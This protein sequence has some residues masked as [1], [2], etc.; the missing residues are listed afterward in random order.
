VNLRPVGTSPDNFVQLR[1]L[2]TSLGTSQTTW[3]I[4]TGLGTSQTTCDITW[5]NQLKHHFVHLRPI[6]TSPA[7]LFVAAH[8]TWYITWYISVHL[9]HLQ[10]TWYISDHLGHLR[11]LGTSPHHLVHLRPLGTA[12]GTTSWYITSFVSG[13][14]VSPGHIVQLRAF[15]TSL[16]VAQTSADNL[17]PQTT[18]Y[19]T[20]D[21][22]DHLVRLHTT[23]YIAD[24]LVHQW[25]RPVGT[26]LNSSQSTW[27]FT[28]P[29]VTAQTTWF[30][31]SQCTWCISRQLGSS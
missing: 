3:Y 27:Y 10:A 16:G 13:Y 11:P 2:G 30:G 22:S 29:R 28:K 19:I 12:L 23:W 17:V 24:H 7:Y 25:L 14:L 20:W 4:S 21:I 15:G 31:V 1:P 5:Y 8:S 6:V 18:W 26:S 9:V